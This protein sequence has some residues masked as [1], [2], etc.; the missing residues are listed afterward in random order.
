MITKHTAKLPETPE[1]NITRYKIVSGM[2]SVLEPTAFGPKSC[3][4]IKYKKCRLVIYE[5]N[6]ILFMNSK[7]Y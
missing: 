1:K 3:N 4:R 6:I 2:R 5:I 7:R